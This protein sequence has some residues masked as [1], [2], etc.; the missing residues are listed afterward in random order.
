MLLDVH[1]E[2]VPTDRGCR[3]ALCQEERPPAAPLVKSCRLAVRRPGVAGLMSALSNAC[4]I[5]AAAAY[6]QPRAS[7]ETHEP[8][9]PVECHIE[10]SSTDYSCGCI[11]PDAS[12]AARAPLQRRGPCTLAPVQ[13]CSQFPVDGM[14]LNVLHACMHRCRY[15]DPDAWYRGS[16]R[17]PLG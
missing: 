1:V 10:L 13:M 15:A 7:G 11:P 14:K 16:A 6:N 4:C 17:R 2:S 3:G 5:T 8:L 12:A 9:Q